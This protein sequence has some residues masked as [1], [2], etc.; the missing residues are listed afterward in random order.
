MMISTSLPDHLASRLT[1]TLTA[2]QNGQVGP[3][4]AE[5]ANPSYADSMVATGCLST[6]PT[7]SESSARR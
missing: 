7:A 6:H 5:R 4:R 1:T 3:V 2:T